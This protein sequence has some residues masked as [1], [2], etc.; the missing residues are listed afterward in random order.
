ML[1]YTTARKDI[2]GKDT[3]K[4]RKRMLMSTFSYRLL[5]YRFTDDFLSF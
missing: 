4:E 2:G 5:Q 3:S 1:G